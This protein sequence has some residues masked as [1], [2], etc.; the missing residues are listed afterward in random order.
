MNL[1]WPASLAIDPL[2]GSVYFVDNYV[3]LALGQDMRVRV[4]AGYASFCQCHSHTCAQDILLGQIAFSPSGSLYA[5]DLSGQRE[6]RILRVDSQ[7]LQHVAGLR[8]PAGASQCPVERCVDL[9]GHNCTCLIQ[10][11]SQVPSVS[12]G[13]SSAPHF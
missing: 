10:E 11:A 6:N 9:G 2:D 8:E 3:L 1:H 12:V 4:V 13:L 7:S 5:S